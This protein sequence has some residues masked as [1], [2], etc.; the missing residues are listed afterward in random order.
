[1]ELP[2]LIVLPCR[3]LLR[4]AD[5]LTF[6]LKDGLPLEAE[7]MQLGDV[8][9]RLTC[10]VASLDHKCPDIPVEDGAVVVA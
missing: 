8:K 7:T 2:I 6:Q 4:Q 3:Y 5:F 10:W 9:S 1:M